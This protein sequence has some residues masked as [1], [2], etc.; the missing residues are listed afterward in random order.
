MVNTFFVNSCVYRFEAQRGER[1]KITLSR[2]K[3]G[4]R[5]CKTREDIDQGRFQCFG[6]T[7]ATVQF[8]EL[9][10][11][12][13]GGTAVPRDCLCADESGI[14]PFTFISTAHIVELRFNVL[15]M[16]STDDFTTMFF[17][18]SWEFIKKPVCS[19]NLR[20]FGASGDIYFR[21]PSRTPDEVC[22]FT[23]SYIFYHP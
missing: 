21:S 2:L 12:G 3:T 17:D 22:A 19:K 10:W 6:N 16:N 8:Y 14:V 18:G 7:T 13:D 1:V 23:F 15:W 5:L 11:S 9:P 20:K 4:D